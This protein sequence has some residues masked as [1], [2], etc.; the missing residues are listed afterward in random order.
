MDQ[1]VHIYV[2]YYIAVRD[3]I[4]KLYSVIHTHCTGKLLLYMNTILM[5][6]EIPFANMSLNKIS[7]LHFSLSRVVLRRTI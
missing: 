7:D 3:L 1:P 2:M 5:H 6:D 4:E